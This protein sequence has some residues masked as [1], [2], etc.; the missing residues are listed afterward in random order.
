[1]ALMAREATRAATS[2]VG[3]TAM[4]RTNMRVGTTDSRMPRHPPTAAM[5]SKRS[6]SMAPRPVRVVPV[7]RLLIRWSFPQVAAGCYCPGP[8]RR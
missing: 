2:A 1:M 8:S 7:E 3:R 6:E 4:T 5:A